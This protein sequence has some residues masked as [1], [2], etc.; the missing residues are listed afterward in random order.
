MNPKFTA[1]EVRRTIPL[2][3][4]RATG[5]PY[6]YMDPAPWTG[7]AHF[8]ADHGIIKALPSPGD[9]LTDDYLPNTIP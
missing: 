5:K 8:F 6:G 9:V 4:Q 3:A 7:F 1:A 2:L